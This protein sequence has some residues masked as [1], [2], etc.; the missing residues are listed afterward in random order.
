MSS[1][2]IQLVIMPKHSQARSLLIFWEFISLFVFVMWFFKSGCVQQSLFC[3]STKKW[4]TDGYDYI[5]LEQIGNKVFLCVCAFFSSIRKIVY[6]AWSLLAYHQDFWKV[7]PIWIYY[8]FFNFEWWHPK[9]CNGIIRNGYL[10]VPSV[11]Q[12]ETCSVAWCRLETAKSGMTF[13]SSRSWVSVEMCFCFQLPD[14]PS[15]SGETGTCAPLSA[16]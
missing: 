5:S 11:K 2:G 4:N 3:K 14:F 7:L 8:F 16:L 12:D 6:L 15:L 10:C 9:L 1:Y 13:S